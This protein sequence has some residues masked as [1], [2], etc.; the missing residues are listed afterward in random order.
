MPLRLRATS[1]IYCGKCGKRRGLA[2]VCMVR[3]AGGRTQVKAPRITL[4]TCPR[5]GREYA[6]PFTHTCVRGTGDLKRRKA[7][8]ERAERK[9][10]AEQLRQARRAE[11]ARR[12]ATG[13]PSPSAQHRY[14]TCRDED[15]QRRPCVAYRQG[16]EDGREVARVGEGRQ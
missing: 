16:F 3:R 9:R 1:P 14:Q 5:C 4:A 10:K 15:C 7:A 2:H 8:A 11:R 12:Q 6:N 13:G